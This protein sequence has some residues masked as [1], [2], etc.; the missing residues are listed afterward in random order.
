M[1]AP[2]LG[3][4][5]AEVIK[6]D[7]AG[8]YNSKCSEADKDA[9]NKLSNNDITCSLYSGETECKN[10]KAKWEDDKSVATGEKA[11]KD[12]QKAFGANT[13][14][15][16]IIPNCLLGDPSKNTAEDLKCRDVGIFVMFLINVARYLFTIIGALALVMFIYGG[17]TLILSQGSSEKVK[18]GTEI[19][20]AAVIGLVIM[21]GAYMLVQY[22]GEAVSIKSDFKAN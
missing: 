12:F 6:A 13:G 11:A 18:K 21:F 8:K 20:T 15:S 2:Q 16:K 14:L 7:T 19:I 3:G 9:C 22:L 17:F 10:A 1:C 5:S 4:I